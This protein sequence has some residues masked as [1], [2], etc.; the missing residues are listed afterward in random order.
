MLNITSAGLK[1][2]HLVF[3]LYPVDLQ[4]L[5]QNLIQIQL[6]VLNLFIRTQRKR[7]WRI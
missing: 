7:D 6:E 3:V 2:N 4:N 1:S 5:I